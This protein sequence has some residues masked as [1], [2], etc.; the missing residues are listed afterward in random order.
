MTAGRR[1]SLVTLQRFTA[2]Q[3][4]YGEEV[5]TWADYGT[6]WAAVFYGAGA[7]RRQAAMEQG[8]QAATFEM[9]SN[10]ST[11]A[12]TLKDRISFNGVAWDIQGIAPETPKRGEIAITATRSA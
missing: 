2:V 9:L 3:D 7:E 12:L 10:E 4:D 1:S 11:R 5:Q 6:E 8:S